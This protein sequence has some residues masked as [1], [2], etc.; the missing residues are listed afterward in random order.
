[1]EYPKLINRC[2]EDSSHPAHLINTSV[3]SLFT[4]NLPHLHRNAAPTLQLSELLSCLVYHG[5]PPQWWLTGNPQQKQKT[6]SLYKTLSCTTCSHPLIQIWELQQVCLFTWKKEEGYTS[7]LATRPHSHTELIS[8]AC[9]YLGW[10]NHPISA[11]SSVQI[12]KVNKWKNMPP[13]YM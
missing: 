5:F 7:Q 11:M 9:I 8:I 3:H 2:K 6:S 13:K 4:K 12:S 10:K 1:M